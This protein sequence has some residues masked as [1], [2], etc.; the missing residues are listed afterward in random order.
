MMQFIKIYIPTLV[1]FLAI[2]AVWLTL[3]A[4]NFYTKYIGHLMSAQPN[5]IPALIFYLLYIVG[6]VI[7]VIQPALEQ[8]SLMK[9]L[10]LGALFGLCAYATYDLTNVATLKNWPYIVVFV[11]LAWGMT[12]TTIVSVAGFYIA[13]WMGV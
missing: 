1:V 2:D 12:V 4:K 8:D 11:D 3:I 9:V 13:K 7:F 6:L 5:L 10:A